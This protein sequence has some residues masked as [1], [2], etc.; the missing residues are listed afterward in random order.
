MITEAE[1][2]IHLNIEL[3]T[4]VKLIK[5]G[6][7][8]LQNLNA[9]NDFYFLPFQLLSTGFERLMKCH[10]CLGFHNQCDNY[11]D[12]V[13]LKKLG[14][15]IIKI[16]S[17]I[18]DKYFNLYNIPVLQDDYDLLKNNE[19]LNRLL[20]ILS[21][22]GK[23][24]RY[25]NLNIVAGENNRTV[26]VI[27]LWEKYQIDIVSSVQELKDKLY[28]IEATDEILNFVS[29][30]I[31][32]QL[33]MFT[34]ALSRQFTLG[35]LGEKAR[36]FST[37]LYE[38]IVMKNDELGNNNYRID[39][40]RFKEKGFSSRKR[41]SSDDYQRMYNDNFDHM[42][43]KK[44]EYSGDWPFYADEVIIECREKNWC[45][46]TINNIDYALNGA[47]KGRYKLEFPYE[48]G[49]AIVGKSIGPFID[50]ALELGE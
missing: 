14:H 45:V 10:V 20:S 5:L 7:G 13:Y 42:L 22:F 1:K 2:D 17:E 47:A 40:T 36:Q 39:T 37:V 19:E 43:I 6:F 35:K 8:E 16:K 25:Y 38:F 30:R 27:A 4:S 49:M 33:E 41:T 50:L 34:R 26:D 11:P 32:I 31:I 15:D 29:R 9:A 21:E 23:Y 48:A 18:I 24:S 12:S 46:V 28:S 44:D 3:E